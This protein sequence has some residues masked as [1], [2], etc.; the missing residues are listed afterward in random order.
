MN[1]KGNT[2]MIWVEM[3]L[4]FILFIT[5]MG[6]IGSEM[7][8]DYGTNH[9]LTMG[10]NLSNEL[11]SLATYKDTVRNETTQGQSSLTD[12]G[13]LKLFTTPKLLITVAGILWDFVSG[14]F[15]YH[16]VD[17]MN[18]GIYGTYIAV[19]FNILYVIAIAFIFLKLVLRI[20]V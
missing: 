15:I 10:L 14:Q 4:F 13:V 16:L 9:D 7:N 20:A 12:F 2:Y 1:K 17:A 8:S 3:I 5:I 19:T 18:L 6:I 11:T